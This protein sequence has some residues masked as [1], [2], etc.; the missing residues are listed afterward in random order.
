[1]LFTCS[2]FLLNSFLNFQW[3][4][5]NNFWFCEPQ[6]TLHFFYV[7]KHYQ[8]QATSPMTDKHCDLVPWASIRWGHL[9]CKKKNEWWNQC[10]HF[11]CFIQQKSYII[12]VQHSTILLWKPSISQPIPLQESKWVTH[13]GAPYKF[14]QHISCDWPFCSIELQIKCI[15]TVVHQTDAH[16]AEVLSPYLHFL[17]N[18]LWHCTSH[19]TVRHPCFVYYIHQ[20][21]ALLCLFCFL[22]K[23]HKYTIPKHK[24]Q[25]QNLMFSV[26]VHKSPA[27]YLW[28]NCDVMQC[29]LI[30]QHKSICCLAWMIVPPRTVI[31][32]GARRIGSTQESDRFPW[33]S[34]KMLPVEA[35]PKHNLEAKV[36]II[37][38]SDHNRQRQRKVGQRNQQQAMQW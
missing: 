38:Y 1:M 25:S 26:K 24:L 2:D 11:H 21:T 17:Q 20:V 32:S 37:I 16:A 35:R 3:T 14:L 15:F 23:K 28:Y 33:L 8:Q 36:V 7:R 18:Y 4:L 12:D 31:C 30:I 10:C 29:T 5:I 13:Q 34:T 27:F 6:D 9:L 19:T 22:H